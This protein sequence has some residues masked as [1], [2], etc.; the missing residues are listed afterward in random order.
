MV[1][2]V[3]EEFLLD[4]LHISDLKK[5]LSRFMSQYSRVEHTLIKEKNK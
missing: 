5:D 2:C 4:W 1:W 3:I